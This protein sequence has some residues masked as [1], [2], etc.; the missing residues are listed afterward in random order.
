M[1][2]KQ[3]YRSF[4]WEF[5]CTQVS[6]FYTKAVDEVKFGYTERNFLFAIL[7]FI[8][9]LLHILQVELQVELKNN[10]GTIF[11]ASASYLKDK[12]RLLFP[13]M[14][15]RCHREMKPFVNIFLESI[16]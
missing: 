3:V 11:Q 4:A 5:S 1:H 8:C 13:K 6:F 15:L 9:L 12:M 10:L 7:A 2:A 14:A 16:P